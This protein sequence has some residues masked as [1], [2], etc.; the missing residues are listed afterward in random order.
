[1]ERTEKLK[2]QAAEAALA[3]LK[4][5]MVL[6]IGTGTTVNHFID[7]LA[8]QKHWFEAV[9]A[10]SVETENR[11]KQ[12]GIPTIELNQVTVD[13]YIDGADEINPYLQLIKGGGGAHTREK[14]I[15]AAAKK[16]IVIA[17][18]SKK[19]SRLGESFP[20]PVEV[21]PMARSYVARQIVQLGGNPFYREHCVTDNGNVILDV[22]GL[23]LNDIVAI[24]HQLNQIVGVVSHGIFCHQACDI[25][26][27][28]ANSGIETLRREQLAFDFTDED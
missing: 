7:A 17:D 15:A 25:A 10:S 20:V 12:I 8:Q 4:P 9:V 13:L 1:M 18:E 24:D 19:V 22:H 27:I 5:D 16:F 14:I 3:Y 21:I 11:L 28:A 2:E 6:G 23:K 26:I